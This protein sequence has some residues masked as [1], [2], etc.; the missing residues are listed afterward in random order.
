MDIFVTLLSGFGQ[1]LGRV[2]EADLVDW[3]SSGENS[4]LR[5]K[6]PRALVPVKSG[7]ENAQALMIAPIYPGDTPQEELLVKNILC[8]ELIGKIE[9]TS[10]VETCSSNNALFMQYLSAID[11]WKAASS[12]IQMAS[13]QDL[14]DLNNT[15][16]FN[17][18]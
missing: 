7:Q 8:V 2:N 12:G 5:V 1:W 9:L 6:N 15:I 13:G 11:Q 17:K 3:T 14:A 10:G 4:T 16:P 18:R